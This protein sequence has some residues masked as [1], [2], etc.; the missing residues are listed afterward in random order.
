MIKKI[1]MMK[2][3]A[4]IVI[5]NYCRRAFKQGKQ[6]VAE[7]SSSQGWIMGNMEKEHVRSI[8][9]S[10]TRIS[11][12]SFATRLYLKCFFSVFE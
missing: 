1:D 2:N 11:E 6:S 3:V 9:I 4:P 5:T 12:Y 8:K 10:W 7:P